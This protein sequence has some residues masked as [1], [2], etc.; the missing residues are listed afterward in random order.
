LRFFKQW[1]MT[2]RLNAYERKRQKLAQN[3]I[4][5]RPVFSERY[6]KLMPAL[7]AISELTLI[8]I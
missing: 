7:N 4:F 6:S 2:M 3:W 1:E 5:A 8:E